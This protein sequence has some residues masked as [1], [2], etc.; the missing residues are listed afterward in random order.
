[1]ARRRRRPAGSVRIEAWDLDE[2]NTQELAAHGVSIEILEGVAEETPRFRRNRKRR[3]AT[4]QMIGPDRGGSMW[5]ICIL[6]T[7]PFVWRPI[8]GW[9][10]DEQEIEWWRRS[11]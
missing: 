11:Q 6:E 1:M 4:Y 9:K 3:V 10:A 5:V 2:A 8:T 7:E